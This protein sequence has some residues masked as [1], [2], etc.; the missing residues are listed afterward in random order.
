M[1]LPTSAHA[2]SDAGHRATARRTIGEYSFGD[3]GRVRV[4]LDGARIAL[5]AA[6]GSGSRVLIYLDPSSVERWLPTADALRTSPFSAVMP[7]ICTDATRSSAP[8]IAL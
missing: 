1:L 7:C 6:D 5:Y 3:N 8:S 4:E 2:Q